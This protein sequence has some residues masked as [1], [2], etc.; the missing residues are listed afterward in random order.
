MYVD[1]IYIYIYTYRRWKPI[2]HRLSN[3]PLYPHFNVECA[4]TQHVQ[5]ASSSP[6]RLQSPN[7]KLRRGCKGHAVH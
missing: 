7:P 6:R 5:H 4:L 2:M 1:Y 3:A